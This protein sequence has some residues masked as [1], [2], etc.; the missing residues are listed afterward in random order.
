MAITLLV[1]LFLLSVALHEIGHAVAMHSRKIRFTEIGFGVGPKVLIGPYR[2]L[3]G[4]YFAFGVFPVMA[5]VKVDR[6]DLDY[7]VSLPIN[8]QALING[9][10]IMANIFFAGVL[11]LIWVPLFSTRPI[12]FQLGMEGGIVGICLAVW[13]YRYT[14]C[15]YVIPLVGSALFFELL[16]AVYMDPVGSVSNQGLVEPLRGIAQLVS[17]FGEAILIACCLSLILGVVNMMPIIPLDGGRIILSRIRQL[18]WQGPVATAIYSAYIYLGL[19]I[20]VIL[21]IV[22][23]VVDVVRMTLWIFWG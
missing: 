4:V 7:M 17:G 20:V 2:W 23:I 5:Y 3:P 18:R 6:E 12:L 22:P 1:L 11:G 10:G 8:D 15:N 19:I 13:F 9:A 16:R 21:S 14:F